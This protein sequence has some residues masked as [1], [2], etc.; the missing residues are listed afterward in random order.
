[1]NKILSLADIKPGESAVI[2]RLEVKGDIRRR[3]QDIGIIEGAK[4]ECIF[5]SPWS[6]PVAYQVKGAVIALRREDSADIFVKL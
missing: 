5:E 3:M 1:M 4:I 2:T 6:D